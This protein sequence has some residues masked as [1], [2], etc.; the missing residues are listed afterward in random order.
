MAETIGYFD[1]STLN[2]SSNEIY[3]SWRTSTLD[4]DDLEDIDVTV[5]KGEEVCGSG[6]GRWK[7]RRFQTQYTGES[8][9]KAKLWKFRPDVFESKQK[10][11]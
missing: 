6:W 1:V 4:L 3:F 7:R 9:L 5:E 2:T 8:K 11:L 10:I